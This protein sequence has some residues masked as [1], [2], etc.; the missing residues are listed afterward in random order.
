MFPTRESKINK[1][2]KKHFTI[3][4]EELVLYSIM[5]IDGK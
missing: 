2:I 1:T 5:S 3:V 4:I